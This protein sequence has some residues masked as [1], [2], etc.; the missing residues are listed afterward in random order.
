MWIL[1]SLTVVFLTARTS[2]KVVDTIYGPV[3]GNTV[4]L[5]DG[6]VINSWYGIRYAAAPIGDLR[7]EV[8]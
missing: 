1:L 5:D 7:F 4:T 6:T 3:D 2:A 8:S